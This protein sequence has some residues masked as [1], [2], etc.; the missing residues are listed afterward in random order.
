LGG[1]RRGSAAA[2]GV[3]SLGPVKSNGSANRSGRR[4]RRFQG[5]RSV[6]RCPRAGNF[7]SF[8]TANSRQSRQVRPLWMRTRGRRLEELLAAQAQRSFGSTPAAGIRPCIGPLRPARR[9]GAARGGSGQ[10]RSKP[11]SG[12]L[13]ADGQVLDGPRI[14][15]AARASEGHRPPRAAEVRP[16]RFP[17]GDGQ[18]D[19]TRRRACSSRRSS[20]PQLGIQTLKRARGAG[21]RNGPA[22]RTPAGCA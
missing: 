2:P 19:G 12:I 22:P 9:L 16:V 15:A 18:H 11:T 8:R 17:A 6:A 13:A 5:A 7:P 14:R 3:A 20:T 10:I 4:G 21:Q 1:A